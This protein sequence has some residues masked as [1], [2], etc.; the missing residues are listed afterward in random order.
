MVEEC[1]M[2]KYWEMKA[3]TISAW[4]NEPATYKHYCPISDFKY[5]VEIFLD[6]IIESETVS[7]RDI[8]TALENQRLPHGSVFVE[9]KQYYKV[10]IVLSVLL[11]ENH[12]EKVGLIK[13]KLKRG[14]QPIKYKLT[15][16]E[17]SVN[18]LMIS[19]ENRR[20]I[21]EF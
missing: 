5:I 9:A 20:S 2:Y 11:L 18:E 12:I 16:Q 13:K 14:R 6:V 19:L 3:K 10:N 17:L 7:K 1:F 8:Y 4:R 21:H 15:T